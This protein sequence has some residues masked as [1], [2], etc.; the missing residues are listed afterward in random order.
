MKRFKK[1]LIG[2]LIV[3]SVMQFIRP[4]KNRSTI[5][6]KT[7]IAHVVNVPVNIHDLL[8]T[9]CY[10]C[11]SNNTNYPWYANIQPLGWWLANHIKEGKRE[12]NFNEFR[13]YSQRRQLSKLKAIAESIKDGSMPLSSYTLMHQ[14]AKLSENDKQAV[15]DWTEKARDSLSRINK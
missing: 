4:G 15:I 8:K 10:D 11:H 3:L 1:I 12:L 9:S 7:D 2:V 6:S 5:I 14:N 13:S